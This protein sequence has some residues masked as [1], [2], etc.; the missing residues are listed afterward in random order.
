M[1]GI[2]LGSLPREETTERP[3]TLLGLAPTPRQEL[4]QRVWAPT[5]SQRDCLRACILL[6]RADGCSLRT[7]ARQLGVS[8]Y[9]V[10]KWS[11]CFDVGVSP[12]LADNPGRNAKRSIPYQTVRRIVK[13]ASLAP[14]GRQR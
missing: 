14:P 3:V 13:M 4:E 12:V 10:H 8:I 9:C 1:I 11:Q 2:L 6:L 5:T 7:E